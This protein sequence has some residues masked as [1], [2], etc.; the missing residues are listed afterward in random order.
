MQL[1]IMPHS[2]KACAL[3]KLKK[4]DKS[5]S[6][7]R[8]E[9]PRELCTAVP[10]CGLFSHLVSLVHC[11]WLPRHHPKLY[12]SYHFNLRAWLVLTLTRVLL[13][14]RSF[15]LG[16]MCNSSLDASECAVSA[17]NEGN[18]LSCSVFFPAQQPNIYLTLAVGAQRPHCQSLCLWQ[19]NDFFLCAGGC[20]ARV[21]WESS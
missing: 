6:T 3:A 5:T 17:L 21:Q 12:D 10:H 16:M 2:N 9:N 7:W 20:A 4:V 14:Q 13:F 8:R 11:T 19:N 18:F 15:C 1:F